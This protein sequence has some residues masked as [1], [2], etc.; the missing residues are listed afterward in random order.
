MPFLEHQPGWRELKAVQH[1]RIFVTDGNQYF[2]MRG[3]AGATSL[4]ELV[5]SV[6]A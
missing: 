5:Q 1:G 4:I 2:A 6:G 3:K